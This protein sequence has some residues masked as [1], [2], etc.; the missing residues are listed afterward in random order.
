MDNLQRALI[1][2]REANNANQSKLADLLGVTRQS[3]TDWETGRSKP[4]IEMY[5]RI[6][7]S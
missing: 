5:S 2:Y 1:N 4:R 7:E 6:A 3:I